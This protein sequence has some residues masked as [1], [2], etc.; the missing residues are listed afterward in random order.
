LPFLAGFFALLAGVFF[1]L[2]SAAL[3]VVNLILVA[4]LGVFAGYTR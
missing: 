3:G 4:V 1:P 2:S